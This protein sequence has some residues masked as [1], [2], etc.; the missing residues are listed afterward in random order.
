MV[1]T[2][3]AVVPWR[4][5]TRTGIPNSVCC[6][7]LSVFVVFFLFF[8]GCKVPQVLSGCTAFSET[9]RFPRAQTDA[10]T[11][12]TASNPQ[13][14]FNNLLLL[15]L[16]FVLVAQQWLVALCCNRNSILA[17]TNHTGKSQMPPEKNVHFMPLQ[18]RFVKFRA[19]NNT[20][21]RISSLCTVLRLVRQ[22]KFF[23]PL[24]CWSPL[25]ESRIILQKHNQGAVRWFHIDFLPGTQDFKWTSQTE[26]RFS[27]RWK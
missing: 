2:H 11:R 5:E 16:H 18:F 21:A 23:Q 25:C 8:F 6:V 20:T 10:W 19:T 7:E 4:Q 27:T 9:W 3:Q 22:M 1:K 12:A 17:F 13:W 15:L 14:V 26:K 24:R